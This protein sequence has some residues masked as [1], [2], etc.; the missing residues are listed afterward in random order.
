[1]AIILAGCALETLEERV[2]RET[3]ESMLRTYAFDGY[4]DNF[5]EIAARLLKEAEAGDARA[6]SRMGELYFFGFGV[7]RDA[8]ERAKWHQRA[9]IGGEHISQHFLAQIYLEGDGLERDYRRAL[10]WY[11]RS[12]AQ[13]LEDDFLQE[14]DRM[15]YECLSP[16]KPGGMED[17][18]GQSDDVDFSRLSS[19]LPKWVERDFVFGIFDWQEKCDEQSNWSGL[20]SFL[21]AANMGYAK[22]QYMV[23]VAYLA[24]RGVAPDRAKA[25]RWFLKAA[26]QEHGAARREFCVLYRA[27]ETASVTLPQPGWCKGIRK[28]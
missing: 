13:G 15:Q 5:P 18:G 28:P 7:P 3:A 1:M 6:Q 17:G 24:G 16:K 2:E 23:G 8:V 25:A 14:K 20:K 11:R 4:P 19:V 22:A 27:G 21:E 26:R 9:A 10:E 12:A